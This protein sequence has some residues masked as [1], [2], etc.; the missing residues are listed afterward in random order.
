M[1]NF[2]FYL[3]RGF[4]ILLILSTILPIINLVDKFTENYESFFK[5][6]GL[7]FPMMVFP[8]FSLMA[9]SLLLWNSV[10]K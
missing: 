6:F 10:K 5:F 1:K 3:T 4:S 9:L 7:T 2:N 8:I